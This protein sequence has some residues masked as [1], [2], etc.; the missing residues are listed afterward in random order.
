[1][2]G[3][4]MAASTPPSDTAPDISVRDQ[5][6][7]SVIG[8]HEDREHRDSRPLA[9]RARETDAAQHHH[10]RRRTAAAG[11]RNRGRGGALHTPLG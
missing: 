3:E 10:S 6:N 1:M 2:T 11:I 7:A 5:P 9:A 4:M 8:T